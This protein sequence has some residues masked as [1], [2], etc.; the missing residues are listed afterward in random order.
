MVNRL[1]RLNQRPIS[2]EEA[3]DVAYRIH[4]YRYVETSAKIK[5]GLSDLFAT[6]ARASIAKEQS[7]K[8]EGGKNRFFKRKFLFFGR[9]KGLVPTLFS[10][11]QQRASVVKK[12]ECSL[13]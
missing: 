10:P 2:Y 9:K 1:A 4:A 8:P 13:I 3:I 6:A 12:Q 7:Y 11:E 5:E